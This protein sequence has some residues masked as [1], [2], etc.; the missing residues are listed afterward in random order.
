VTQQ[1][2]ALEKTFGHAL[3][4]G[5]GA[6]GLTPFGHAVYEKVC[7]ILADVRDLDE[8]ASDR[9]LETL[10][11]VHVAADT[12]FGLYVLPRAV[13]G[14]QKESPEIRV[15]TVVARGTS[16]RDRLLRCDADGGIAGHVWNDDRLSSVP[17]FENELNCFCAP[18][19]PLAHRNRVRLEDLSRRVLLMREAKSG[20]SETV[21]RGFR[22]RGLS[23]DPA[24]EIADN[25]VASWPPLRASV[26][27][28]CPTMPSAPRSPRDSLFPSA[29]RDSRYGGTWHSVWLRHLTLG[30]AERKKTRAVAVSFETA[31]QPRDGV[32]S[33]SAPK[34]SNP[35]GDLQ[36][37]RAALAS[38]ARD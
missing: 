21:E 8:A 29:P 25:E 18:T 9:G 22:D 4:V 7:R 5:R 13:A 15:Q 31:K 2:Q 28:C 24:M 14:F 35:R 3:F 33:S 26:W 11:T 16:I 23:L 38:T 20:S 36:A 34:R 1:I 12:T 27:L 32:N 10:G 37:T 17:L 19:H 6:S 30:S